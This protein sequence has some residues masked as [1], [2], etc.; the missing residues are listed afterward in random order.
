VSF[1]GETIA[2]F[3]LVGALLIF[4]GITLANGASGAGGRK[5]AAQ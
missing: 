2:A 1:L 3:H 4:A 5:K